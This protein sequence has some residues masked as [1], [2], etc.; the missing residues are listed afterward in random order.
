MKTRGRR[1]SADRI[2]RTLLLS[3][4]A[5]CLLLPWAAAAQGLTGAIIGTVKDEQGAAVP[6]AVVRISSPAL[7]GGPA[8]LVTSDTGQLRF[9]LLPPGRY[10]LEVDKPGF[11]L[12]HDPDIVI[13]AGATIERT[14]T[15]KLA[16]VETSVVVEGAGSRIEARSPGFSTRFGPEDVVAIPTRRASMF[17]FVRAAPG[18]SPTSPSSGVATTISVFGSGTNENLFLIDGMNTTCPCSGVARSEPGVDFIQEVQVHAIGASAEFGNMQ[19]GV[20]SV[21]TRQGSERFVYDASYYG[22]APALTS[23]PVTLGYLGSEDQQSGYGR[24]RYQDFT[25]TLGGPAVRERLWFF[26]G[27]Q[28][29]P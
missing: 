5:G 16:G 25:T 9:A 7:I 28:R 29:A 2:R 26:G 12:M 20:I 6:G 24:A 10:T 22:Q 4:A 17:D 1:P 8:T 18:V 21:V 3:I 11:A 19:G 14:A 27:Y 15:L 23:Q 13:A